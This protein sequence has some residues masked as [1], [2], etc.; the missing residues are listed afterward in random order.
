[1]GGGGIVQQHAKVLLGAS[2][3]PSVYDNASPEQ[4]D[5]IDIINGKAY[6]DRDGED[7]NRLLRVLTDVCKC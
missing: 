5:V 3:D 4:K 2:M 7:V 1:M 6:L